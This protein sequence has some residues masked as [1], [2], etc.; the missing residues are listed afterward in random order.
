M[1]LPR[2]NFLRL[3]AGAAAFVS[4]RRTAKAQNTTTSPGEHS[5]IAVNGEAK[6]RVF[7]EGNGAAFVLLPGQGRGPRDLETLAKHLVSE[8]YRVIRPEPRGFGKSIGPIEGATLRDN[9]ADVAASIEATSA[10][11]AVVVG[12]A[13]GNRVARMLATERPELVRGVVLIAAGGKFQPKPEIFQR[14]R[15]IKIRACPCK[16]VLKSV[17]LFSTVQMLQLALRTCG[18]TTDRRPR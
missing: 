13:Y 1:K 2:R 16:N 15:D 7:I 11:P 10:A 14:L 5:I 6:L 8:G 18:W 12:F 17:V 3:V 4:S 9:A